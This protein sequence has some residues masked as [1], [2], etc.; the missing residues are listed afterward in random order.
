M[1][2]SRGKIP[3]VGRIPAL[4]VRGRG[5]AIMF[6]A[7]GLAAGSPSLRIEVTGTKN[8][9]STAAIV[10]VDAFDVTP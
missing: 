2:P 1:T 8:D 10:A 6:S 4:P 5:T 7:T 3:I 9:A